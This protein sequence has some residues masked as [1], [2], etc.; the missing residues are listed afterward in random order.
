MCFFDNNKIDTFKEGMEHVERLR[1]ISPAIYNA[2]RVNER[3]IPSIEPIL[4]SDADTDTENE[5]NEPENEPVDQIPASD[6]SHVSQNDIKPVINIDGEDLIAFE[7]LFNDDDDSASS[8]PI[9][10]DPLAVSQDE[11]NNGLPND[12]SVSSEPRQSFSNGIRFESTRNC[13]TKTV[14]NSIQIENVEENHANDSNQDKLAEEII[15]NESADGREVA[16]AQ[17]RAQVVANTRHLLLHGQKVVVDEDLEFMHIPGQDLQAR[18]YTPTYE[19]KSNDELC[20]HTPFKQNVCDYFVFNAN[21]QND[22]DNLII[23][24]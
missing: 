21:T 4:Q 15:H 10:N 9:E 13:A 5:H 23:S 19:T 22:N 17:A 8:D 1:P 3:P 18:Q 16:Q 20:G 14:D 7:V 6:P 11:E 24:R 2:A 12:D